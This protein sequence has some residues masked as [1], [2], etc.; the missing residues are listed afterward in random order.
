MK[1]FLWIL[2]LC[3][4]GFAEPTPYVPPSVVVSGEERA[5]DP[6]EIRIVQNSEAVWVFKSNGEITFKGRVI[7]IDK[8][9]VA[10]M[11]D[12]LIKANKNR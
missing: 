1:K 2:A 4:L 11:K 9:F 5:P 3:S 10:L 6:N 8:E 12:F 7:D